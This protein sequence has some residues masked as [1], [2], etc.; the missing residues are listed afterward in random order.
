[1]RPKYLT[2]EDILRAMRNT[3]SNRA[4]ARYLNCSYTHYKKFAKIYNDED[5]VSL[6]KKHLNP[7]G[8]GIPKCFG[9]VKG[10]EFPIIDII[11][12]RVNIDHFKPEKIKEAMIREGLLNEYCANCG[13]H[14]RRVIDFKMPLLMHF[15][16]G[17]KRNYQLGNLKLYCY[18]CFFL[19]IGDVFTKNQMSTIQDHV[20]VFMGEVDWEL[21][22]FQKQQL[23]GLKSIED[24]QKDR[25]DDPYNLVSRR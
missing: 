25:D 1:M 5:G 6:F 17:N 22:D 9:T 18:N 15:E 19:T 7:S 21:S 4:A 8:K 3:R 14:E 16:D 11:E 24:K 10:K 2:K 20:P 23:E 12:G 13:F